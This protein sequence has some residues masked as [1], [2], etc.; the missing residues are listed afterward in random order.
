MIVMKNG[1][2]LEDYLIDKLVKKI[3]KVLADEE[4]SIDEANAILRETE[5]RIGE[6]SKV[7]LINL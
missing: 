3:I 7:M 6:T 1:K 5:E 2:V 4:L